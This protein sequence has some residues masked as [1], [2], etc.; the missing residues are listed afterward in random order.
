MDIKVHYSGSSGNLYQVDDLLIDPGVPGTKIKKALQYRLS[1]ICGALVSHKHKDHCH[2]IK[3]LV[4]AGIDVYCLDDC[5]IE[6]SHRVHRITPGQ[7]FE[8]GDWLIRAFPLVHDVPTVGFLL[9][10]K[11]EYQKILYAV[12]TAYIPYRFKKLTDIIIGVN[13]DDELLDP[14][15]LNIEVIKRITRS[16]MSLKT[17]TEFFME[18]DLSRLERIYLVHLSQN[19][20]DPQKF[21]REIFGATG[22]E[23]IV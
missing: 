5:P 13:Y 2:G 18:M 9:K 22:V 10:K 19:N 3:D 16:H 21:R 8:I 14:S 17:A 12:D 1:G 20:S 7:Q 11:H 15:V 6:D 4:A 23:V